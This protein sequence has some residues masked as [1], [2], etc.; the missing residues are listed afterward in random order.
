M[1]NSK[2]IK[3]KIMQL[4][5]ESQ[6]VP[7]V[8]GNGILT[9]MVVGFDER[10]LRESKQEIATI[11]QELGI[12]ERLMISLSSLTTLKNGEVW[13]QLQSLEDFQALEL[14]LAC[15]DACG[16]I[17]N[18][19]ATIQRNI[20]EIGDINSILISKYGRAMFGD[21]DIWLQLIREIVVDKM[22]FFTGFESIKAFATG[23]QELTKTSLYK[24][25]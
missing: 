4:F 15:S 8:V 23:N 12:D 11:L 16:F 22:Y 14:L 20:N 24:Y 17:H 21:D 19:V 5:A 25:K 6:D 13:N 1:L 3:S 18:D 9:S 10:K 7:Y 2:D